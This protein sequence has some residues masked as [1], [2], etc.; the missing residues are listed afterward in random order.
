MGSVRSTTEE[1]KH[2]RREMILESARGRFQRF[3]YS[4][5]TMEEIAADAGISKGTIYIYFQN[6]EDILIVLVEQEALKMERLIYHEIKNMKSVGKQLEI[7]FTKALEYLEGHPFMDSMVRR[8]IETFSPRMLKH[9]VSVE[10]RYVAIIEDYVRRGIEGGEIEPYNPRLVAYVMYKV[11]EAFSYSSNPWDEGFSKE[12][13]E[14]FVPRLFIR[15]LAPRK[16]VPAKASKK[17]L[18]NK[19]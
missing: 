1:E 14:K 15:G 19:R 8:D 7:I 17:K 5:T 6:K 13:V 11:F 12:E 16:P 3:G 10:D 18:S 2:R 4:K 9:I